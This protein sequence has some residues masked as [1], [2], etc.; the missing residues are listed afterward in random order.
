MSNQGYVSETESWHRKTI[1]EAACAALRKNGFDAR[2]VDTGEEAAKLVEAMIT[3]G[4][5]VATGGSITLHALK[6][7]ERAEAL[8]AKLLNHGAKGLSADEKLAIM[9]AQLTA[10]LMLSSTNALTLDGELLNIDGNGNRV[11]ALTFGP[12]KT[13]VIA[14]YNKITR[15]L[16][17]AHARCES[18]ASPM[19]N[20]R[21]GTGNPCVRT[22]ICADCRG[23]GRICKIYTVLRQRPRLSDFTVIV[24]GE[25]LGY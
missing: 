20:K 10:D 7:H 17:E 25:S 22:G 21:L 8:G 11:A 18:I 9:R 2:Y 3:P 24:V 19:N 12:K 14:G 4:M 15:N 6:L 5:T 1:G 16:E 23:E 13:V